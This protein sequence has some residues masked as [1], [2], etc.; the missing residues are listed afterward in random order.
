MDF[1]F[2]LD[3]ESARDEDMALL[4]TLY[5]DVLL[6]LYEELLRSENIP[7]LKKDRGAGSAVRILM[8]NNLYGTDLFV[9]KERLEEATLLI[10]PANGAEIEEETTSEEEQ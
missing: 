4:A 6:S 10:T 1:L 3:R 8:G 7:Y 9:Q 5:D 2:G